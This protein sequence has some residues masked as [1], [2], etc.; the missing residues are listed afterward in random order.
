M[1]KIQFVTTGLLVSSHVALLWVNMSLNSL[2]P[3]LAGM[4]ALSSMASSLILAARTRLID[5]LCGGADKAYLLHRFFGYA[6]VCMTMG[7]WLSASS[8]NFAVFSWLTNSAEELGEFSAVALL[9]LAFLSGVQIFSYRY[10]KKLHLLMG[11]LFLICVY[12]SLFSS[13]PFATDSLAYFALV[14]I[15]CLGIA[16]WITTLWQRGK[17]IAEAE[18][19]SVYKTHDRLDIEVK[20]NNR[21]VFK[22]GQFAMICSTDVGP[23]YHPF[24]IASSPGDQY[25]RFVIGKNGD[26]TA[27]MLQQ[28]SLG[29][30]VVIRETSG[31]F[32]P[33][34]SANRAQQL[35]VASGVGITPFLAAL[36]SLE[37]DKQAEI[38]LYYCLPRTAS[39]KITNQ[40]QAYANKLPQFK[41]YFFNSNDRLQPADFELFQGRKNRIDLY[42]CGSKKMKR[43]VNSWWSDLGIKS[44]I[45]DEDFDF[46]GAIRLDTLFKKLVS[47]LFIVSTVFK[48]LVSYSPIVTSWIKKLASYLPFF[49]QSLNYLLN[50]DL[51]KRL[52]GETHAHTGS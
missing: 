2:F 31:R 8:G 30:K 32:L 42:L 27:K 35:W 48:K 39:E 34:V 52:T 45:Y 40:L 43:E 20:A 11:P 46:R 51:I 6:A 25:L 14:V 47:Y 44:K 38:T 24:T 21:I 19:V 4:L 37:A 28:I 33:Q 49:H 36:S 9:L 3:T 16:G 13:L 7:H 50:L 22:A 41:V 29:S 12:H 23:E 17:P 1:M 26:Y 15:S 5:Y 10:W 18:V